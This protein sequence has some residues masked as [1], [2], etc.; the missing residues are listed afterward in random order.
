VF[1]Y[2]VLVI[3]LAPIDAHAPCPIALQQASTEKK[4]ERSDELVPGCLLGGCS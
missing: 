3:E 2:E 1:P 4:A